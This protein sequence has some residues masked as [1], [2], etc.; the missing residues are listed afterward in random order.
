MTHK[1]SNNIQPP[2]KPASQQV[3]RPT[4]IKTIGILGGMS[5]KATMEYYRFINQKINARLGGWE[6]GE[7]LIQGCNFGNIEY[8]VRNN[9]WD[10]A[11]AYVEEKAKLAQAG[12]AD[13]L[14]CVSN[15]MHKVLDKM[16]EL[17]DIPFI[18]IT[19][20]TAQAIVSK[21][22]KKIALL[23]TKPVMQADY[24]KDEYAKYGI[25]IIVPSEAEQLEIDR[26]IFDELVKG[27]IS[28]KSR[29]YYVQVSESL[30]KEHGAQGVILGCT[31]IF[32]LIG[33]QDLQNM[34]V[35]NTTELHVDA[36]VEYALAG[37]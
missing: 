10:E 15:T 21:G 16:P 4:N 25:E 20:P 32:L 24:I 12:G 22:L 19:T 31:E 27:T 30:A 1:K 17:L 9:A 14:V 33:Q 18:H 6:I 11:R 13:V 2:Q 3:S 35:F 8:Y 28:E 36:A 5:D 7:T 23:G 26:I 37:S 29:Q 34:T